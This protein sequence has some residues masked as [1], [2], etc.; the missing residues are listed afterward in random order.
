MAISPCSVWKLI[1]LFDM[2]DWLS[3][4]KLS[5]RS[6]MYVSVLR[7]S[8]SETFQSPYM[9]DAKSMKMRAETRMCFGFPP[10]TKNMMTATGAMSSIEPKSG[11]SANRNT[12]DQRS[13]M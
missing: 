13:A 4:K 3:A 7:F 5:I 1:V 9:D 6:V 2:A 11:W 10:P 12:M 8:P